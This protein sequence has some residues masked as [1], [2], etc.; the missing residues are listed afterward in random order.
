MTGSTAE[1]TSEERSVIKAQ[2]YDVLA[3]GYE[4]DSATTTPRRSGDEEWKKHRSVVEVVRAARSYL[5]ARV[6]GTEE[7]REQPGVEMMRTSSGRVSACTHDAKIR[8][9]VVSFGR[10][11]RIPKSVRGLHVLSLLPRAHQTNEPDYHLILSPSLPP[12]PPILTLV[13]FIRSL[14]LARPAI[15]SP[16]AIAAPAAE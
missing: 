13:S 2:S 7:V 14:L 5:T 10:F 3:R 8:F 11:S 15:L 16:S 4:T 6:T 12:P 9:E 1:R